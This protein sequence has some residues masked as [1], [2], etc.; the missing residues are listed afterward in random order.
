[1]KNTKSLIVYTIA[2]FVG[3]YLFFHLLV[4]GI[5]NNRDYNA[6][7]CAVYG[8]QPDCKTPLEGK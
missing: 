8:Y 3:G 5:K 2:G 6:H 1:M 4:I 7:G